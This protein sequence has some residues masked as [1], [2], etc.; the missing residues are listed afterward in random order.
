LLIPVFGAIPSCVVG[1]DAHVWQAGFLAKDYDDEVDAFLD[2]GRWITAGGSVVVVYGFTVEDGWCVAR[3]VVNCELGSSVDAGEAVVPANAMGCC[4]HMSWPN[5]GTCATKSV[6]PVSSYDTVGERRVLIQISRVRAA[7]WIRL[8]C[9]T[10]VQQWDMIN[11]M[12]HIL[13]ND[14]AE[15]NILRGLDLDCSR[16]WDSRRRRNDIV[17]S[18]RGFGCYDGWLWRGSG[19]CCWLKAEFGFDEEGNHL[20]VA[21]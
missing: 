2:D 16:L 8:A 7:V 14:R 10:G 19:G 9:L 21:R 17:R 13:T 18:V 3:P 12:A 6:I 5:E 15:R 1:F 11:G 20:R 4:E